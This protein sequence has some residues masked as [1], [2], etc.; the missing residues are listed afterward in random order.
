MEIFARLISEVLHCIAT[1]LFVESLMT[2]R[3]DDGATL[4]LTIRVHIDCYERP[5][6]LS[7]FERAPWVRSSGF[8]GETLKKP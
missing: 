2:G 6:F 4:C 8:S 1:G 3:S 7:A 5:A